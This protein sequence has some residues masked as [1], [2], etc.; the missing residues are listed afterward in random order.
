MSKQDED[1]GIYGEISTRSKIAVGDKILEHI[2][3]L[4]CDI[5]YKY[6]DDK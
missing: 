5:S 3:F 4:L 2:T 1:Y 6:D